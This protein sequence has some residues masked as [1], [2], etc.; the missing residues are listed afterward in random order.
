MSLPKSRFPSL[1]GAG[2]IWDIIAC[3]WLTCRSL[4]VNKHLLDIHWGLCIISGSERL[5]RSKGCYGRE[6]GGTQR[7]QNPKCSLCKC[8]NGDLERTWCCQGHS[9]TWQPWR[10]PESQIR[11]SPKLAPKLDRGYK[12]RLNI[13]LKYIEVSVEV[14]SD[15]AVTAP[16]SRGPEQGPG[17]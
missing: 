16:I 6:V 7:P 10:L 4:V 8:S 14:S 15:S 3:W 13:Y 1:E 11:T 12:W 2:H 9:T 17:T 5:W